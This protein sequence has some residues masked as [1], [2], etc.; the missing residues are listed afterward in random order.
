MQE[1]MPIVMI[2]LN[3]IGK[4]IQTNPKSKNKSKRV[5]QDQWHTLDTEDLRFQFSQKDEKQ[6]F[7]QH[8]KEHTQLIFN[9]ECWFEQV[10]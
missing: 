3:D 6:N 2:W 9:M 7:Y 4:N 5:K 10:S 1:L 8:L